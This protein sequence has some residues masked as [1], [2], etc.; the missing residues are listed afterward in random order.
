MNCETTISR[1]QEYFEGRLATLERNEF[2]HHVSECAAC[3]DEVL[4]YREVFAGL[5]EMKRYHAPPALET[6]VIR[7]LQKKGIVYETP[8][9]VLRRVLNGFLAMPGVARYPLAAAL[10]VSALYF[11]IAAVLGMMGGSVS[12]FT[13]L[14]SRAT[15]MLRDATASTSFLTSFVDAAAAYI[16][17]VKTVAQA[18]AASAG[19]NL[20][21]VGL[22]LVVLFSA[23]LALRYLTKR[24]RSSHDASLFI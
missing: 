17:G 24:K 12:S 22:G 13:G 23:P 5:R 3:E 19:D 4:A 20:L 10:V 9:P 18:L 7:E 15:L 8:V 16:R 1:V 11:P 21:L 6:S 2:V 14:V